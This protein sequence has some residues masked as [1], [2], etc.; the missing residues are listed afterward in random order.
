MSKSHEELVWHPQ[1]IPDAE[2]DLFCLLTRAVGTLG[3]AFDQ[4]SST[5][6][7]LLLG[8]AASAGRDITRQYAHDLLHQSSYD[9]KRAISLLLPGEGVSGWVGG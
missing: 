4:S 7:P 9:M 2:V 3:R 5:R 6:Q 1:S 8:A